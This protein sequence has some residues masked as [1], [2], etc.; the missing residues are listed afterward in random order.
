MKL[1]LPLLVILHI[2]AFLE[3][4]LQYESL[5]SDKTF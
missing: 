2:T 4:H 1:I 3:K 5:D